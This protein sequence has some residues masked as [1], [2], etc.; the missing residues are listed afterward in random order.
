MA[1]L[2][3][4]TLINRYYLREKVG[5]GGMADV[6]Q[7]WD[8][9]RSTRLAVKILRRDLVVNPQ[10][11]RLFN[12]EAS[13]Y[14]ELEHPNIVRIYG[15]EREGD[16]RFIVMD[17]VSGSSLSDLIAKSRKPMNVEKISQILGPLCS[18][19][20]YAHNNKVFHCDVKPGNFP[21]I[22]L[23]TITRR[24][25]FCGKHSNSYNGLIDA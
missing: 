2:T 3:G 7:A 20:H 21:I 5:S 13:L 14:K 1:S 4:K 17:W 12:Q 23:V 18:A 15:F 24:R 22:A 8:N 9:L 6:Y 16:I 25:P 11:I 19:L 10:Y